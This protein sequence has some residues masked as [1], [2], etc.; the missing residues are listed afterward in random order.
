M[1]TYLI[2]VPE[3][4]LYYHPEVTKG[5]SKVKDIYSLGVVLIEI[6]F[7][8]PL[9][10]EKFRKM[11]IAQVSG[12]ILKDLNGKFGTDLIGDGGQSFR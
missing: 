2:G 11:D 4:D 9:F 5:W 6:A 7:W 8:R 3:L 1:E 10:E 12:A